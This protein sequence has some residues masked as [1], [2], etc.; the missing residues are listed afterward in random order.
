MSFVSRI[1]FYSLILMSLCSVRAVAGAFSASGSTLTLDLNVA[2]Q[3]VSV[4]ATSTTYTF[5]LSGGATNTW[6]GTTSSS[7]TVS[8]SVLTVT[9]TGRSTFSTIV[10]TDSQTGTAVT[11]STSGVNAYADNITIS[12]DNSPGAVSFSGSS[13]FSG[14]NALSVTTSGY[15]NFPSGSSLSAVDGNISLEAN[16]QTTSNDFA[17]SGIM[18]DNATI[19]IT[20]AGVLTLRGKGGSSGAAASYL[21]RGIAV[22]NGAQVIGGTTGTTTIE[23]RGYTGVSGTV[24]GQGVLVYSIGGAATVSKISSNGSNVSVTGYGSNTTGQPTSA[25]PQANAGVVLGGPSNTG[26]TQGGIIT[27]GG[28]GTVTVT[29]YGGTT[30]NPASTVS[31]Y[32]FGVYMAGSATSITSS[33]GDVSITGTAGGADSLTDYNHGVSVF[34]GSVS[35]GTNG[36]LTVTG[37]GGPG[38]GTAGNGRHGVVVQ[39]VNG[40][41]KG[42]PGTGNTLVTGTGGGQVNAGS[43][44]GVYAASS[45]MI[46]SLGSGT[47]TVI[48]YGGGLNS[49]GTTNYGVNVYNLCVISSNGGN[50]RVEGTGGG[51]AASGSNIGVVVAIGSNITAGGSGTVTVIGT[52]GNMNGTSG[53]TNY[54]VM[55]TSYG[56]NQAEGYITSSGGDVTVTGYGGGGSSGSSGA[57]SSNNNHGVYLEQGGYITSGGTG[58][59]RV[60]GTGGNTSPGATGGSNSGVYINAFTLKGTSGLYSPQIISAGG[61]MIINGTGGGSGAGTGNYGVWIKGMVKPTG[62]G[63]LTLTGTGGPATGSTNAGVAVDGAPTV[64][65]I[66]YPATISSESGNI[67]ITGTGGGASTSTSNYGVYLTAGGKIAPTGSGNVIVNGTGGITSGQ[68]NY[69]VY[70]TGGTAPNQSIITSG[71]G[72]VTVTGTGPSQSAGANQ[73]G[74]QLNSAIISSGGNGNVTVSGTAGKGDV[75]T[76]GNGHLGVLVSGSTALVS[77]SGTGTVTVTGTGGGDGARVN[78]YGVAVN[79]GGTISSGA[80]GTVTVNGNGGTVA[81]GASQFGVLV[82]GAGSKITSG[83]GDVNINATEGNS[84]TSYAISL[85]SSGTITTATNGGNITLKGNSFNTA[86]GCPVSAPA[87]GSVTFI[88][89]TNNTEVQF[90]SA[91]DIKGKIYLNTADLATVTAGD[92]NIGNANT[93]LITV[94]QAVTPPSGSNLTL[95]GSGLSP[96]LAGTE[97]TMSAGKSLSISGISSMNI[98]IAGTAVNTQYDQLKIAGDLTLTGRTLTL[99]GAYIPVGGDVFIIVEATSITGN[100]SGLANG[101]SITFNGKRLAINYTATQVTLTSS[102]SNPTSGGTITAAQ[103]GNSPF[104]PAAFTSAAAAS[105]QDGTLEYKWQYSVTSSSA[106]FSDIASSN[107]ATYDPAALTQTTW[108]KRVARAACMSDW[109]GAVESNVLIVTVTSIAT[110]PTAQPTDLF[111]SHTGSGTYNALGRFTASASATD[112]LVVR[113]TGSAPTFTPVDGTAYTAGSQTGGEIVYAGSAVNFTESAVTTDLAYHYAIYA[114]NG[115]GS[116]INYLTTSPLTG[117]AFARSAASGTLTSSGASSTLGFPTAGATVNFTSGTSGTTVSVTRNNSAPS[118]NIQVSSSIRG[119]KPLYFSITSSTASP[120]NYTLILDFSGL[121]SLTPTQWNSYKVTKR[122]NTNSPWVD[123]TTIGGTIVNRQTDGVWGK[124]TISGL[125]SFSEFGLADAYDGVLVS[126]LDQTIAATFTV[127][128]GDYAGQAF[129][130]DGIRYQLSKVKVSV[131]TGAGNLRAR[132]YGSTAGGN[133]N[134]SSTLTNFGSPVLVS[135]SV[136]E[137]TPS[138]TTKLEPNTQYWLVLFSA[139]GNVDIDYTA[140]LTESGP[141]GFPADLSASSNDIGVSYTLLN[142]DPALFSVEATEVS[143]IWTGAGTTDWATA[144]NW[145]PSE[146]PGNGEIL[147]IPDVANDPVLP[148]NTSVAYLTIA[149]GAVVDLADKN[150]TV[151]HGLSHNGTMTGTTGKLIMAGASAQG[152]EGTGTI[153]NMEINNTSGVAIFAGSHMQTL[154]GKFTPT[155]GTLTTNG[156]LTL[157]SNATGTARVGQGASGGGYISGDVIT[158]RHLTKLTG[159]GRNGRA[160]RL[161]TI[162]VSGTETLRDVFMAGQ[163]GTDLTVSA[164]RSVQPAD[165]GTVVI[166]HNQPDAATATG[167]GFDWIG[168]TGQVSSLRY[169]QSNAGSGSFTSAQVPSLSTTYTAADQGYMIFARGDRQ[170]QYNGTGN[171]SVTTLQ[172]RGQLKQGTINVTIPPLASAGFVLVG[173]PYMSVLDMEKVLIDNAGVIDNTLY[174]W[175]ANI[176]GNAFKQGGYRAV[177]RTSVSNW[178]ASGSGANPQFIESGSA[179][180]VKPTVSG[181]TLSIKE[182]HKVD[183]TPGIAPHGSTIDG[184]SRIFINLEVTDTDNRRLVDG[185]VVFFESGFKDGLGDPVDILPM[186]NLTAGSVTLRQAQSRLSMEGRPWPSDSLARTISVDMRNLGDDAYVLHIL[187]TNMN[188]EGFAAWLKDRY[189]NKETSLEIEK[190]T[191]YPFRRTGDI[192]IDSTRFEIVYRTSM[193]TNAGAL[194]PDVAASEIAPRLYPNPAKGTD[195]KLSLG[196][197]APGRYEV[198]VVDMSGRLVYSRS[199]D[200]HS[201]AT[202]YYIFSTAKLAAGNYAVLLIDPQKQPKETLR[203]V[204]DK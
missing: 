16:M 95:A 85:A 38:K 157:L 165:L 60:N 130:T 197:L 61:N 43:N 8:G 34:Q 46:S 50:V 104:D 178:T 23:G 93:G 129:T 12:L 149:S 28:S 57:S 89:L 14:S 18:V 195:V 138:T 196:S 155:T 131:N 198:Q 69:G 2:S 107:S 190:E 33:G 97:I 144:G 161:V 47:V 86:A 169:F 172:A 77:S 140:S 76:S 80:S 35:T 151:T 119:M 203:L 71:G 152:I 182:S 15:V 145:T 183:G 118:S 173:N 96:K 48:G 116:T 74:V 121:G 36:N 179:F 100:F 56:S 147:T 126:N 186:T 110:E 98:A 99:S 137:F 70:L 192:G 105:G 199:I 22:I 189:L 25:S 59:V 166:G 64:N 180:F 31:T 40:S 158:Q 6:S 103:S 5:T 37:T 102:C 65:T 160:W 13:S 54:G 127:T 78:N 164:N 62:T 115:S 82:T 163:S 201:S 143:R 109:V 188:K 30:A 10:I 156:N 41:I 193:S 53:N 184:P 133:V 79:S 153:R 167:A 150:L 106:G 154:T 90:T 21:N 162:P 92:I 124:F 148:A 66:V 42:G 91:T 67:T 101:D 17:Y 49:T 19:Q 4:A 125:S 174:V 81:A 32:S 11:F 113:N 26:S 29:G 83:G 7:V 111:F 177:T 87:A 94:S 9:A 55:C 3:L 44:Y 170:Q 39:G 68:Q 171:A 168:V 52:G 185:A 175:D 191:L 112:Y 24:Q 120:G 142:A 114:F 176:D 134:T 63:T 20:G 187:P 75:G 139:S 136:Y 1:H 159:T 128:T 181:G 108:Y 204:V 200:H 194:T 88:P 123:V 84:S 27:A 45:A 72:T 122:A 51:G 135:G 73:H 141:A 132:L 117:V 58:T 146:A 202:G